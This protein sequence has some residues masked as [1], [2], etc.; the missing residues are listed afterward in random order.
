MFVVIFIGILAVALAALRQRSFKTVPLKLS[1]FVIFVFLALRYDYGN[2]YAGYY[3]RFLN[4][5][6]EDSI[7]DIQYVRGYEWG[8]EYLNYTFYRLFGNNG[9]FIMVALL[10]AVHCFVLYHLAMLLKESKNTVKEL[11]KSV[12]D[13]NSITSE[14]TEIVNSIKTPVDQIVGVVQR[15]SSVFS[16]ASGIIDGFKSK[17]E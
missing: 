5:P 10:A 17:E 7:L 16:V 1:L 13:I 4:L 14:L 8:W 12:N 3:M 6:N 9:F 15:V 2:D 11:Q